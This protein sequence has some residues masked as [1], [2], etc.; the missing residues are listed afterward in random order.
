MKW[1]RRLLA[2]ILSAVLL[3]GMLPGSVLAEGNDPAAVETESESTP[4]ETPDPG[5]ENAPEADPAEE[6]AEKDPED[7][8]ENQPEDPAGQPEGAPDEAEDPEASDEEIPE[9]SEKDPEESADELA[10][11]SAEEEQA[12]AGFTQEKFEEELDAA[13]ESYFLTQA[14]TL[15]ADLTLD[16]TVY[17]EAGGEIV[18]PSGFTLTVQSLLD[19]GSSGSVEVQSGGTLTIAQGGFISVYSGSLTV[20]QG[21]AFVNEN[22][23]YAAVSQT[24][25]SGTVEGIAA[26]EI[27]AQIS[28]ASPDR[29]GDVLAN[30]AGY[31]SVFVNVAADMELPDMAIMERQSLS[32]SQ[33]V[34]AKIP[35]G[36]T[37]TSAG[38]IWVD[39][40]LEV[41]GTLTGTGYT[42]ADLSDTGKLTVNGGTVKGKISVVT[43]S[44]EPSSVA[45]RITGYGP[46]DLNITLRSYENGRAVWTVQCIAGMTKLGTPTD[47]EWGVDPSGAS[48]PGYMRC[49]PVEP[50]QGKYDVD[51][52]RINEDGSET[53]V[54]ATGYVLGATE[55]TQDYIY[56][57]IISEDLESGT[58]YFTVKSLGDGTAYVDSDTAR[59]GTW[60]YERPA[61]KIGA[62][63]TDLA[64]NWPNATARLQG[65]STEASGY[66]VE[67][68]FAKVENATPAQ[69]ASCVV[70]YSSEFASVG[71]WAEQLQYHG[72]GWYYFRIRALSEDITVSCNGDWSEMSP[73]YNLT[74]TVEDVKQ[75]LD[76]I[77]VSEDSTE[78]EKAAAI[79]AVRDIDTEELK[80][81][82]LADDTVADRLAEVEQAAAGGPAEVE[83]TSEVNSQFDQSKVSVVGANLN[84]S[85]NTGEPIRLVVDK[86]KEEHVLPAQFDNSLAV[87]FSMTLENSVDPHALEVP[88]QVKLP[89]PASINPSF[90][91]ILHYSIAGGEP[92]QI[93]PHISYEDGQVYATFVLTGFSDFAMVQETEQERIPGD[94][95]GDGVVNG[96][97]SVLLAQYL[98]EWD[99]S[100]DLDAADVNADGE[101]NG[102]DSVLLAQYLAEWDVVLQEAAL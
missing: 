25:E 95:N 53:T 90:L 3:L 33:G 45:E 69:I 47:L 31:Y 13:E 38:S 75:Q 42:A 63:Y 20:A 39:G 57:D 9:E 21:G 18:V 35:Q 87:K 79:S 54:Y 40:T 29:I 52:I 74:Q 2:L 86:P 26:S 80:S 73:G 34:T 76:G 55:T 85:E 7:V 5:T 77:T 19:V 51:V 96:K 22:V 78:E 84:V 49:M 72:A 6:P 30:E 37:V 61:G 81:A 89:V 101:V 58:Y 10:P 94:V 91:V 16:K 46:D 41:A 71:L 64:W 48:R 8:Q 97:D 88:V 12:D 68:Y 62:S 83:V 92:E 11:L 44:K 93:W 36:I 4:A 99:V 70:Y 60:V 66:K 28:V 32:I 14:L 102:K 82:M 23:Y 43:A 65:S 56:F 17:V 1:T 15:T 50:S 24:L 59:S 98:A 67:F 27:Q 100:I